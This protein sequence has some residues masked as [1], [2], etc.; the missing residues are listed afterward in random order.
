MIKR[1]LAKDPA[2][3]NESWDRFLPNFKKKN[4]QRKKPKE[5][6]KKKEY[7]PF[8]PPQQPRKVDLQLESGEYFLSEQAKVCVVVCA[9]GYVDLVCTW[10]FTL[11]V[12]L[13]AVCECTAH[14]KASLPVSLFL[15][16]VYPACVSLVLSPTSPLP[17]TCILF[18]HL[19]AVPTPVPP[20]PLRLRASDRQQQHSR[21][22]RWQKS[23]SNVQKHFCLRKK[24]KRAKRGL[25]GKKMRTMHLQR[26]RAHL[27][28]RHLQ[29]AWQTSWQVLH[30]PS[31]ARHMIRMCLCFW[32]TVVLLSR[33]KKRKHKG[34]GGCLRE[35]V[36]GLLHVFV[37]HTT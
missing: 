32:Q 36:F 7:T 33:R 3:A 2:L 21:Q 9:D 26:V 6:T 4:V 8:P 5:I 37:R 15:S 14:N 17:N 1:E 11:H 19:H 30:V 28:Q 18:P 10:R 12:T 34:R 27:P 29:R 35:G 16:T 22:P 23:N 13:L 24:R 25:Q 31:K 20:S